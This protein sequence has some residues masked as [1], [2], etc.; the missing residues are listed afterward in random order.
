MLHPLLTPIGGTATWLAQI[1]PYGAW[2]DLEWTT[3]WGEGACGMYE[4]QW[5]MPLPPDFDHPALRSG[6]LVELMDGPWR[7]GS[8]LILAEPARGSGFNQPWQFTATG[9]GREVEGEN[10]FYAFDAGSNT[11]SVPSTAI[12]AAISL[13][14]LRW[15]GRDASV[16]TAAVGS[17]T[18]T[19]QLN[20]I[21]ALLNTSAD[22]LGKRW[23]VGQDNR[24]YFYSDPTTPTYNVIPG[25]ASLGVADDDYAS[26]VF[27]RYLESVSGTYQTASASSPPAITRYGRREYPTDVTSLGAITTATAQ[28]FADG[29]LAKSKARLGWTNGLTLTSNQILTAGGEAADLSKVAEDVAGGCMVRLHGI[30][31]DLLEYNGQTWLDIIIG[32]AKLTDGE[33]SISLSPMGLAKRDLA[34]IV[35][36]VSGV[37]DVAA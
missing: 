21:G 24:V 12:D 31:N 10:S 3:R 11:T 17:S 4:A 7:I 37:G 30:F 18:S 13:Q 16:S 15:S 20:T 32:E 9:I 22:S 23:G 28:G 35:E 26:V 29:I 36:E 27:V 25:V 14:G 1:G 34:S 2:G 8:P 6:T 33:D 19:D 5:S